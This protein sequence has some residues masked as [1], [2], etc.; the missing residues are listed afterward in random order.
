MITTT[1]TAPKL[2][3]CMT[4]SSLIYV[5]P[6]YANVIIS[7][8]SNSLDSVNGASVSITSSQ[9]ALQSN[10]TT[11]NN[12]INQLL[13]SGD[14]VI[15]NNNGQ[16]KLETGDIN[17]SV[18]VN[19]EGDVN[20]LQVTNNNAGNIAS[21]NDNNGSFS[22]N[23]IS[24]DINNE[25]YWGQSNNSIVSNALDIDAN[26]GNNS[27]LWSSG[28]VVISTGNIYDEVSVTN[29]MGRNVALPISFE[30]GVL[31]MANS[32]NGN[33]S[34]NNI[35]VNLSSSITAYQTNNIEISNQINKI[36]NTGNNHCNDNVGCM[37]RTGSISAVT[38]VENNVSSNAIVSPTPNPGISVYPTS[39]PIGGRQNESEER[40]NNTVLQESIIQPLQTLTEKVLAAVS[41]PANLIKPAVLGTDAQRLPETGIGSNNKLIAQ[42]FQVVF[43][44]SILA[45]GFVLR[46]YLEHL[47]RSS[48]SVD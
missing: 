41:T 42:L 7:N 29:D 47:D 4:L 37:I 35:L 8:S 38:R 39:V 22:T 34:N 31:N 5:N 2:L 11:I 26:T 16:N 48:L 46:K 40:D 3:V 14:N 12:D 25:P 15:Q 36:Q 28:D 10:T 21:T 27:A 1:V 9:S 20:T 18:L 30:D 33:G 19:S 23:I 43:G 6:I 44:M 13:N 32:N 24:A 17:S 45:A